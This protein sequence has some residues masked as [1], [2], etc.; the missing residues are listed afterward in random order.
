MKQCKFL[1]PVL[2]LLIFLFSLQSQAQNTLLLYT[3]FP[4]FLS[5]EDAKNTGV[6]KKE[7]WQKNGDGFIVDF[8]DLYNTFISTNSKASFRLSSDKKL[9]KFITLEPNE[10]VSLYKCL[11]NEKYCCEKLS[12]KQK[13][14]TEKIY[15]IAIMKK[16]ATKNDPLIFS[17]NNIKEYNKAEGINIKWK[18]DGSINQ[19]Y[20][21][22]INTVET[23]WEIND[24]NNSMITF[25]TIK[26]KLKKPFET[27]HK[28]QLN[29]V[30]KL[31]ENALS[32]KNKFS[33]NFDI[34]PLAFQSA[35]HQFPTAESVD[36]G[37]ITDSKISK[38]CLVDANNNELFK[39]EKY[40]SSAFNFKDNIQKSEIKFKPGMNYKL[41]IGINSKDTKNNKFEYSFTVLLDEEESNE[42]KNL[43]T[44]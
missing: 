44:E 27:G 36:I 43:L 1:L 17:D 39:S 29:I 38:I 35:I 26:D 8:N 21:V 13:K 22:D 37:W 3:K 24:F 34:T 28:Y 30:I 25:E 10:K 23:I 16:A 41:V 20:I 4:T 2:L 31:P 12:D 18:T 14:A 32:K 9:S 40:S 7:L 5:I 42:L 33:F 11:N 19:M 15:A 6:D